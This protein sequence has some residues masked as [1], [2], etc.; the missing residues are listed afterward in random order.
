[1]ESSKIKATNLR[2]KVDRERELLSQKLASPEQYE[3]AE[4]DAAAAQAEYLSA[5][6]EQ[7][8]LKS[9]AVDLD[10][11]KEQVK[12]AQQQVDL[13]QIALDNANQQ[14]S[15]TTVTAPMDGVITDLKT[16]KGSMTSSAISVI[17]G[18]TVMTLADLSRIFVLAS[19]DEADIGGVRVGQSCQITVDAFP[20][21]E[22]SGTVVR[23]A[24]QGQTTRSV[25]TFEVKI[26]VTG[27]DKDLLRPQMTANVQIVETTRQDVVLAPILSLL[28]R[29]DGIYV[30]VVK[31]HDVTEDRQVETGIDDGDNAEILSGISPGEKILVHHNEAASKWLGSKAKSSG[32][33]IK[34]SSQHKK[35]ATTSSTRSGSQ[36]K[37]TNTPTTRSSGSS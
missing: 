13:D 3:D 36:D 20:R 30:T 37:R 16:Q 19:V 32:G 17:G 24:P 27:E 22:F 23:I 6:V 15:Y 31:D 7:R 10:V 4:T 1:V 12:E 33:A 14:L 11:K 25:V 29:D 9:K 28:P 2:R 18:T 35:P 26:E 8:Q 21:R 5:L 34:G